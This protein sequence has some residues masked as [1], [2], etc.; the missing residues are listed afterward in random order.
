MKKLF[1]ILIFC[2]S[3]VL[4]SCNYNNKEEQDYENYSYNPSLDD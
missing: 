2:L 1:Y 4:I 3:F